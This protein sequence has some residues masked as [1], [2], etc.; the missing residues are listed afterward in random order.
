M[1]VYFC[2]ENYLK[3]FGVITDNVDVTDFSPLVEYA[4]RAYVEDILGTVFFEDLVSKYNAK[5]LSADEELIVEK[6]QPCVAWRVMAKAT[7]TLTY[8][9][10]NKGIQ[11]QSGDNSEAVTLQETNYVTKEHL[12]EAY[13]WE[14]KLEK[15]LYKNKSK[16]P[17]YLS[18]D[19]DNSVLKNDVPVIKSSF[20]MMII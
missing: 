3:T 7:L 5:T 13:F 12:Q 4:A 19:N 8:Q 16:F 18:K 11:K 15:W 9:L 2:T 20:G 1:A 6:I 14:K 17:V 10:K